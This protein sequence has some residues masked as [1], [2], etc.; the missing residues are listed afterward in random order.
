M[1]LNYYYDIIAKKLFPN[2]QIILDRFHIVQMLTRSFNSCRIQAMKKHKNGSREYSLLKYYWKLY[3]KPFESLEKVK[4]YY[5]P[6]LKDTLS[7]EQI[8]AKGVSLSSE[9]EN[10]YDLMQDISKALRDRDTDELKHLIKSR[11]HAGSVMRTTL[12]TFRRNLHDILNAA[13]FD[14]SNGCLD[15]INCKIKQIEHTAYGYANFNHLVA[16]IKLEEKDAIIKEQASS[17]Y[18]VA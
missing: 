11:N 3:L 16:R 1:D 10:T 5:R 14:E 9:L 6:K 17:Y 8:V 4:P 7:Q 2:A 18:Q 13:K 15:G 12:S